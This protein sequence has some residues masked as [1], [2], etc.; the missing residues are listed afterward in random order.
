MHAITDMLKLYYIMNILSRN[1]CW[2]PQLSPRRVIHR[3]L[4]GNIRLVAVRITSHISAGVTK[5][6]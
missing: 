3:E 4:F 6:F 1:S 2:L 5:K